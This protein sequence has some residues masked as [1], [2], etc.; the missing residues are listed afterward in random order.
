MSRIFIGLSL[1]LLASVSTAA[2]DTQC[3]EYD[4]LRAR[5]DQALSTKNFKQYCDALSG[6]IKLMPATPP[7][8]ARLQ[9]EAKATNMNVQTWRGV[10]AS[11]VSTMKDTFDGQCR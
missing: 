8:Q 2:P 4:K 3:D 5:R 7:D 1:C 6:L 9:C 11:V 10:R